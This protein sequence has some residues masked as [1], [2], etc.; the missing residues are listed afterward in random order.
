MSNFYPYNPFTPA[1]SPYASQYQQTPPQQTQPTDDRIFVANAAA[2]EA[3]LVAPNGFVRL[4]DSAAPRFYEKVADASGRQ[5]PMTVYT[6]TRRQNR[7]WQKLSQCLITKAA[8]RLLP[9][10]TRGKAHPSEGGGVG[11]QHAEL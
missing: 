10:R 3:Y 11:A 6:N 2:A 9:E 7:R 4:W 8:S 1:Y 5:F